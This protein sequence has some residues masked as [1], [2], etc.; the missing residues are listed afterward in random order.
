MDCAL[1]RSSGFL[2]PPPLSHPVDAGFCWGGLHGV[3]PTAA[4]PSDGRYKFHTQGTYFPARRAFLIC[5]W[6]QQKQ[7]R[8]QQDMRIY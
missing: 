1:E 7:A 2:F 8:N 5:T 4:K 6:R 3:E